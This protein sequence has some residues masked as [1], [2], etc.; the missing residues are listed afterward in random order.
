MRK[1]LVTLGFILVVGLI[2]FF[3]IPRNPKP[4]PPQESK[5]QEESSK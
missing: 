4:T 2:I 5:Y 3:S 1:L